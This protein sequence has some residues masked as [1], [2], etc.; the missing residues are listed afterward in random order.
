MPNIA[1]RAENH[2][3]E[4]LLIYFARQRL[5]LTVAAIIFTAAVAVAFLATP[6]YMAEGSILVRSSESQRSPEVLE[7]QDVRTFKVTEEDLRSERELLSSPAVVKGAV[8]RLIA[9]QKPFAEQLEWL[10]IRKALSTEL[11]PDSRVINIALQHGDAAEAVEI[12][13]A[14]LDEYILLRSRISYPEGSIDFFGSQVERFANELEDTEDKLIKVASETRTP[15]PAREIENNL[16]TKQGIEER[17]S[18]LKTDEVALREQ[19][20]YLGT[21]LKSNEPRLFASLANQTIVEMSTRLIDL[22][23]E[24]GTTA[25]H[26]E[27]DAGPVIV[28]DRQIKAGLAQLRQEVSDYRDRLE[29]DLAVLI[30]QQQILDERLKEIESRNL[31]LHLQGMESDRLNREAELLR[32]SYA[33]FFT[34]RQEAE[35]NT[36]VDDAMALFYVS[37]LNRAYTTGSP[38]FPNRPM[39]LVMGLLA[40]FVTGFSLGFIREFFDHSFKNPRDLE[41]FSGLPLLFSI[42]L[43]TIADKGDAATATQ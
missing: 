12:L 22:Q 2:L 25:R 38:V 18:A 21:L 20:D 7:N 17:L 10:K 8:A 1:P 9:A 4:L 41:E 14:I 39:L 43:I 31:E 29:S 37:V 11:V 24:R 5:I 36:R 32:Q 35:I 26:Y 30:K 19:I 27:D 16:L 3:R 15:V 23:V 34:R 28:I 33:T 6:R 13:D 40:G 42:P